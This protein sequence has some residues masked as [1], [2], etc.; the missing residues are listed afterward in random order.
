MNLNVASKSDLFFAKWVI[1]AERLFVM[2]SFIHDRLSR[3]KVSTYLSKTLK[4]N[5][6]NEKL[7]ANYEYV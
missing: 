4:R 5:S 1:I 2:V 3:L 7:I 6:Q